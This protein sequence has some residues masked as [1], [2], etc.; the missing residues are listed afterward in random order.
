ME[1]L[2]WQQVSEHACTDVLNFKKKKQNG[3]LKKK[4]RCQILTAAMTCFIL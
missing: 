2:S 1:S 4:K 3:A